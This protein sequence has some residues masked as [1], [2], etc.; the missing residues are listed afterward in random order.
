MLDRLTLATQNWADHGWEQLS[1]FGASFSVVRADGVI[2]TTNDTVL[3]PRRLTRSRHEALALLF[4]SQ[5]GELP[6]RS[7]STRLM[8]HPTSVTGIVD[9]LERLGYAERAPHPTDR[10]AVL[11]R[12]T[13]DGRRAMR[14]SNEELVD[15]RFGLGM[16]GEAQAE[17]LFTLLKRVRD[18]D[19]ESGPVGARDRIIAAAHNW[20]R[21]GWA[22]GPH[23]TA[24]V[25]IY[26]AA[27]LIRR[28]NN[29]VLARHHL[30]TARHELL[31]LLFFSGKGRL[32]MGKL[33]EL[34]D[35]HPTSVTSTVS[36]LEQ[37]G[38]VQRERDAA[39]RRTT[40]AR[41]TAKGRRAIR[42]SNDLMSSDQYG[43][44]VLT[45]VQAV[46]L[47][48]LL[49]SVRLPDGELGGRSR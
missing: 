11:A 28:T 20:R 31:A 26:R 25:S 22:V 13:A 38:L 9:T 21:H 7:L 5:H 16:L 49:R 2:N 43:L 14:D 3:E 41:I 23:F 40:L 48:A 27:G 29:V 39:D 36:T 12:I 4:F 32:P 17:Q 8:V 15:V 30:T 42:D 6:M 34:L 46:R 47:V 35:V 18:A 1:H 19:V 24:A 45:T 10:R 33:S 44:S 37:L